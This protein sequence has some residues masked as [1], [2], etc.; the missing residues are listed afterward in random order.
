MPETSTL[1]PEY[2]HLG[3]EKSIHDIDLRNLPRVSDM[4]VERKEED[5]SRVLGEVVGVITPDYLD[6]TKGEGS[7]SLL[8]HHN[9]FCIVRYPTSMEYGLAVYDGAN[10]VPS[11]VLKPFEKVYFGRGE[12]VNNEALKGK[13]VLGLT[14]LSG[15]KDRRFGEGVSRV[16]GS[17]M[18]DEKGQLTISDGY[19]FADPTT[20]RVEDKPSANGTLITTLEGRKSS[21]KDI[22]LERVQ[23][24][25]TL[26][27]FGAPQSRER[28]SNG[29]N[30]DRLR[31][32]TDETRQ[33]AIDTLK[34]IEGE[35]PGLLDVIRAH[36]KADM[37]HTR[38]AVRELIQTD[39]AL[40][41]DMAKYFM[42]R[43]DE[44]RDILPDGFTPNRDKMPNHPGYQKMTS[45]EYVALLAISMLDGTFDT[46]GSLS[47]PA[48][49]ADGKQVTTINNGLHRLAANTILG[50]TKANS[51]QNLRIVRTYK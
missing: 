17:L 40:R 10:F 23:A 48:E 46:K 16:Q 36:V 9:T 8:E 42:D 44:L 6:S 38:Q 7:G 28:D 26:R 35:Q 29:N 41:L 22:V 20:R 51:P 30:R 18:I 11:E 13:T 39:T 14:A 45:R 49:F 34:A 1:Q 33:Q 24:E 2:V 31:R 5:G 27:V 21:Q 47:D 50:L 15:M 19:E 43:V 4:L 25:H 32:M 3:S 12:G 37:P